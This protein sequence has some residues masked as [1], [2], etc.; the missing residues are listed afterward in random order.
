MID[1]AR[2]QKAHD[3]EVGP[4]PRVAVAVLHY[5][6]PTYATKCLR[7]TVSIVPA[8]SHWLLIGNDPR[9]PGPVLGDSLGVP[10]ETIE[11]GGSLGF[12]GG[13]NFAARAAAERGA[14]FLWLLNNDTE[15]A[16][17]ALAPLL[18]AASPPDVAMVGPRII[19]MADGHI[20][21]DGGT[22]AWPEG[23]PVSLG[24]D[25][26][27]NEAGPPT[28]VDFVCGC[29][30]L[31]RLSAFFELGGFDERFFAY[32]ED[33]DL[34]LRMIA[35]GHRLLHVPRAEVRHLG[36]AST[37]T[38]SLVTRYYALRN[39]RLFR[40]LHAPNANVAKRHSARESRTMRARAL[41]YRLSGRSDEAGAIR[42]ALADHAAGRFGPKAPSARTSDPK[43]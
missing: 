4:A 35:A 14:E 33:A 36:S 10:I 26:I 13:A 23:R 24:V 5:G 38:R 41:R 17:G 32:Y 21:H 29:A 18:E 27:P 3:T 20:W 1:R 39:R 22:I 31:I 37:G 34:S 25:Q 28:P 16:P 8:P 43:R 42:S 12:A 2:A 9:N 11:T 6:D 15:V 19:A 30:P 7:S 40:D